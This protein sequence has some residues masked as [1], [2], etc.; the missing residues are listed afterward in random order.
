[1]N[2]KKIYFDLIERRK[3][4]RPNGYV[5]RHHIIPCCIGGNNDSSNLVYLTPEEHFIAHKLLAKIYPNNYGLIKAVISM[6]MNSKTHKRQFSKSYGWERRQMSILQTGKGNPFYGKHHTEKHKQYISSLFKSRVVSN[7]SIFKMKATKKAFPYKY[8]KEQCQAIS[9]R[10]S[11]TGNWMYGKTH[12]TESIKKISDKAKERY[13]DPSKNP[14]AKKVL[15]NGIEYNSIKQ[16][17]EAS[18]LS[19][20]KIRNLIKVNV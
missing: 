19:R 14:T 2:Y 9:E 3:A 1:M 11:G 20:Y 6:G 18:G 5:E 8:S 4:S 7:E 17:S 12:T 10:N 15:L 13:K 16:A